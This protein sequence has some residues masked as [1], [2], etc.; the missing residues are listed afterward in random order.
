MNYVRLSF[1][2][3]TACFVF[4]CG[5]RSS[6]FPM[7]K[8]FWGTEDYYNARHQIEYKT[9][10][11][12]KYP[13]LSDPQTAAIFRKLVDRENITAVTDDNTLGIRHRAEF[14][15]NMFREYQDLAKLYTAMDREDKFVYDQELVEI[16]R[17]GLFL[18]IKY[19][20]IG[21]DQLLQ[22]ADNA[23][24]IKG[25]I[26]NNEQIIISNFNNYLD[27]V[28]KEKAFSN[29]ALQ[30]YAAGMDE[31]FS[32]LLETFPNG[33][34]NNMLSKANAMEKKATDPIV[35]KS[36]A[37]L[38]AKLKTKTEVVPEVVAP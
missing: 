13:M 14:T 10:E 15:E 24:D 9:P 33:K 34:Y 28:N 32:M 7:D 2:I 12:E 8:R 30:N 22:E 20:K 1:L 25:T 29:E 31:A 38:I 26:T 5:S 19:F 21:N 6:N 16:Q 23:D 11:G 27:L 17:F 4:G 3:L 35:K 36:L 37:D 18:Q